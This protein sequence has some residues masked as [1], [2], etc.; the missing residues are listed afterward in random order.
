MGCLYSMFSHLIFALTVVRIVSVLFPSALTFSLQASVNYNLSK[1]IYLLPV[2]VI[3]KT[4][5]R[6]PIR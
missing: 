3:L 5:H 4:K 6:Q 1:H 2:Y